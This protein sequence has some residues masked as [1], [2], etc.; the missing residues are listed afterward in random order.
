MRQKSASK[1]KLDR[2]LKLSAGDRELLAALRIESGCASD[3]E[4]V[5]RALLIYDMVA[6]AG[7]DGLTMIAIKSADGEERRITLTYGPGSDD[8]I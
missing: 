5:R 6:Q 3:I 2:M 1:A 8:D 4:V 7:N